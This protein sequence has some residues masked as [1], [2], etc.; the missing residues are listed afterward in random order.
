MDGL[1]K[2]LHLSDNQYAT[3][4]VLFY[5]SYSTFEPL[6]NVLIKVL[7]PRFFL[8]SIMIM[9]GV[10]MTLM[11]LVKSFSGLAAARFFLGVFEAGL[12]PGEW[13]ILT[14]HAVTVTSNG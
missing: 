8:P 3:C 1:S 14:K 10:V 9:W 11:G 13:T 5:L 4:L 6:T 2:D 7:S 12:F